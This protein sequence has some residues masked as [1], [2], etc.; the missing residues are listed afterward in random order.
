M[1]VEVTTAG[2]TRADEIDGTFRAGAAR[3]LVVDVGKKGEPSL[4]WK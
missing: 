1:R 3:R 4:S 2:V